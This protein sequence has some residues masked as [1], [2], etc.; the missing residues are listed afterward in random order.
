[1]AAHRAMLPATSRRRGEYD[2]D[3]LVGRAKIDDADSL[4]E[5]IAILSPKE[6]FAVLGD[7]D[8]VDRLDA[9]PRQHIAKAAGGASA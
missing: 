7:R 4:E 6:T 8:S 5:A 3:L 1:M 2:A 9:I